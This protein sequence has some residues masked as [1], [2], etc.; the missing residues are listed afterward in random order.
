[1]IRDTG[2]KP[3]RVK[4]GPWQLEGEIKG[5]RTRAGPA[6]NRKDDLRQLN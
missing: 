4:G 2:L 6:A 1:M 3:H 5:A